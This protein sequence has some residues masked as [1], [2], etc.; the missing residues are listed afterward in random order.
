MT[1]LSDS[2]DF[3]HGPAWRNRLALAPLTNKQ[4]NPD[5]TLSD[6]EINWLLARARNGFGMVMTAAAY[7]AQAGKAWNGQLG[8][9]DDAHLPGLERLA[10]GI[11]DA[12]ADSYLAKPVSI[13]PF[14]AAVNALV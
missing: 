4:S 14:M 8:I 7:V 2:L 9:S 10:A 13:G 6:T 3:S 12:G 1:Q 5:G 11:R